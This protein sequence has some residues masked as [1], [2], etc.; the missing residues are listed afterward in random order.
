M[1]TQRDFIKAVLRD[2]EGNA[3][4]GIA[5]GR[6][7][8]NKLKIEAQKWFRYPEDLDAMTEYA[9][10]VRTGDSR[11]VYIAPDVYGDLRNEKDQLTRSKE[12]AL[13]T[14]TIHLDSDSCP[15]DGYRIAPSMHVQ[16]SKR[17]GHD[18]WFLVEPISSA[19]A[20]EIAHR[21]VIAHKDQGTDPSAWS[22]NKFLRMPTVNTTYDK[23]KPFPISYKITGEVFDPIDI[24][25]VYDDIEVPAVAAVSQSAV[26]DM[27]PVPG[28]RELPDYLGLLSRIPNTEKRL[29]ELILKE[30]KLGPE[31]WRNEQ[32]WALILD[33]LRFGFNFE[34]TIS[35]AWHCPAAR[36]WHADSRSISG[37]AAEV[38]KAMAEI[39]YE[40]GQME[41][42][43]QGPAPTTVGETGPVKLVPLDLLTEA[44]RTWMDTERWDFHTQY[45]EYI[46]TKV[47]VMN[48][49]LHN[50]NAWMI[51]ASAFG[52]SGYLPKDDG[53]VFCNLFMIQIGDSSSGKSEAQKLM[54]KF[55]NAIH[56]NVSPDIGH[57]FS[58]NA[59]S[60]RLLERKDEVLIFQTDE[61]DGMLA[62]WAQGGWTSGVKQTLTKGY[63]GTIAQLGR[64]GRKDLQV[65]GAT[66][67]LNQHLMGTPVAMS[68]NLDLTMFRDGYLARQIWVIGEN[69][70][71]TK[72]SIKTKQSFGDAA[73]VYEAMPKY[74][75]ERV[76]RTKAKLIESLPLGRTQAP[77]WFTNEAAE[78]FDEAKWQIIQHFE[79]LDGDRSIFRTIT[80]RMSD[81]IW[82]A[83]AL[84]AMSQGSQWI[85]TRHLV[86]VLGEAEVWL[87]HAKRMVNTLSDSAFSKA[88]NEIEGLIASR[89]GK[90]A[91][92]SEIYKLRKGEPVDIVDR[93]IKSLTMQHRIYEAPGRQPGG[94]I[95][96]KLK[97]AATHEESTGGEDDGEWDD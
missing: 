64:V 61:A 82:K 85:T 13:F 62:Q 36:K 57:N 26:G 47:P 58:D 34:E 67:I 22:A 68:N 63:D 79:S 77:I 75:A 91:E 88:C 87:D 37:L 86:T 45:T 97:E 5:T 96:Y 8:S 95:Y 42:A 49:P 9:E 3:L 40:R 17:H 33:L 32:R 55:I 24:S 11:N 23:V 60:E 84:L 78:R 39:A 69:Y 31:G 92:I 7:D 38:H 59:L 71:I 41:L 93:Y 65:A 12:N 83:A 54:W 25:G 53:K 44:E 90:Q 74:I 10:K 52:D 48:R 35:I 76:M 18:Y 56:P 28:E 66:T 16:T 51:L 1:S 73:V 20:S 81:I 70:P 15:P 29:N 43:K 6:T 27:P 19:E 30:P 4:M 80:R 14:Q 2:L 50:A 46:R 72:E 21:M 94:P 89:R